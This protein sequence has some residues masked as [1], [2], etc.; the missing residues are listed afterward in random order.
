MRGSR[1]LIIVSAGLVSACG[2]YTSATRQAR[3]EFY[4]GKYTDAAKLLEKGAHEDS[5]NQLLFLFDRATALHEAGDYEESI[6]DFARADKLAEIKDYTSL[7]AEAATLVSTDRIIPYKGEDF[8]KVLISQY[9]ALNYLMLHKYEDALVECRRVNHKLHMM[10]SQ[11]K[12]K[13]KLNPF[14]SY[15]SALMY[16]DQKE[17]NDAYVDYQAVQKLAPEFA[18]LGQDLYRLAWRNNIRDDMERWANEYHLSSDDRKRIRD[19]AKLPELVVIVESGKSPEKEPHPSWSALPHYVPRYNPVAYS[20]VLVDGKEVGRSQSLFNVEATAIQNLDDKF[21]GILA[22]HIAGVVAKEVVAD[23]VG[24]RT[25]PIVGAI[26][27]LGLYAVDQADLRSWLTLPKDFQLFRARVQPGAS[28]KLQIKP[29]DASGGDVGTPSGVIE[30]IVHFEKDK[31]DQR[32]F[33][34]VR[35]L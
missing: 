27:R 5:L 35:A 29:K 1:L 7:A 17:W 8:E 32:V 10:I 13:Y 28:Y 21:A 15:I 31:P 25:D 24:K 2:N 19:E 23:Q 6:K 11:G 12:R 34:H 16:E 3:D 33:V 22:K 18:Y 26:L 14:A 20:Q 30:K 9:L 4:A